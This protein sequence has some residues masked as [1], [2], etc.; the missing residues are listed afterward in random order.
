V[1]TLVDG[2]KKVRPKAF[3]DKILVEALKE[4]DRAQGVWAKAPNRVNLMAMGGATKNATR[5][6][7][8]AMKGTAKDIKANK[9]LTDIAPAV[10]AAEQQTTILQRGLVSFYQELETRRK[11]ALLHLDGVVTRPNK[12]VTAKAHQVYSD[13]AAWLNKEST[14]YGGELVHNLG[15][16]G[17]RAQLTL[18]EI[19]EDIEKLAKA[20]AEDKAKLETVLKGH[21]NDLKGIGKRLA[22]PLKE[23]KIVVKRPEGAFVPGK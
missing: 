7:G 12:Q 2:W 13:F 23:E 16:I 8:V 1:A 10:K 6:L 20:R 19:G 4:L 22:A 5:A 11:N 17:P 14:L 21:V 18:K 9:W 15:M 3:D